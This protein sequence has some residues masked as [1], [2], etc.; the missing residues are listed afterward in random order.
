MISDKMLGKCRRQNM[1]KYLSLAPFYLTTILHFTFR[2][3]DITSHWH[4]ATSKWRHITPHWR[5]ITPPW[6]H[7]TPTDNIFPP[8][9]AELPANDARAPANEDLA[10]GREHDRPPRHLP[11]AGPVSVIRSAQQPLA[12]RRPHVHGAQRT[13]VRRELGVRQLSLIKVCWCYSVCLR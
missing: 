3:H 2:W 7:I 9:P 8:S 10:G 5:H 13:A 6:R 12:H 1:L 11:G 4:H